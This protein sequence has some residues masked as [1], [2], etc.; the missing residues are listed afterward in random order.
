MHLHVYT[1]IYTHTHS[2]ACISFHVDMQEYDAGCNTIL[3]HTRIYIYAYIHTI[4]I[5]LWRKMWEY[6]A[7]CNRRCKKQRYMCYLEDNTY[8]Y[9]FH[10]LIKFKNLIKYV[11]IFKKA[12]EDIKMV[13]M[14]SWRLRMQDDTYIYVFQ[15]FVKF[16]NLIRCVRTFKDITKDVKNVQN[17]RYKKH[18]YVW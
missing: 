14:L 7:G 9:V 2:H 3:T 10:F 6:D 15:S 12:I 5:R 11:R 8:I 16:E 4:C 17:Q 1:S 18:P 13:Y